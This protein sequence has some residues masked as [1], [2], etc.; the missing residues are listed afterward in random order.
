VH[1]TSIIQHSV[2]SKLIPHY[3]DSKSWIRSSS[4]YTWIWWL[5]PIMWSDQREWFTVLL[6]YRGFT[7]YCERANHRLACSVQSR[8]LFFFLKSWQLLGSRWTYWLWD[9]YTSPYLVG[10]WCVVIIGLCGITNY[11]FRYIP[12][13]LSR[14]YYDHGILSA[15]TVDNIQMNPCYTD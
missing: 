15:E 13:I 4:K 10:R 14:Y 7:V 6:D 2:G 1:E 9:R 3:R 12:L 5:Y 11:Q 8:C